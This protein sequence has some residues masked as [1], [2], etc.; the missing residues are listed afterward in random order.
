MKALLQE[1]TDQAASFERQW[2]ELSR[3]IQSEHSGM[4]RMF[5]PTEQEERAEKDKQRR[6]D[7]LYDKFHTIKECRATVVRHIQAIIGENIEVQFS[8]WNMQ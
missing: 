2:I 7:E 3:E 8:K 6:C 1:L 4:G 5:E